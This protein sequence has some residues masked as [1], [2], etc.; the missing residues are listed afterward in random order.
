MRLALPKG[1][2]LQTAI[3]AFAEAGR[4]LEGVDPKARKLRF[5]LDGWGEALLLKDWDVSLYVAQGIAD[6]GIVGSDVLDELGAEDLLVPVRFRHGRS[7]LSMIG[8]PGATP[9]PGTQ[10]RLASKYPRTARRWLRTQA[11][12][13]EVFELSGSVELG[14]ILELSEVALDI[15]QTGRTLAENGLVELEVVSE[16]AP[17]L[18][19]HR[20][21][22]QKHRNRLNELFRALERAGVVE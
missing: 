20:A 18:V 10:V 4:P 5:P 14:P 11:W 12:G 13:A 16:V 8:R 15:V 17:V 2:N 6:C 19:V 9:A 3:D 7:R 21:A 1:R 22:W